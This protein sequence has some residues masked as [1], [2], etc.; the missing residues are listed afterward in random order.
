M[1][2][3]RLD[4]A[5]LTVDGSPLEASLYARLQRLCVRESVQL[6]DDVELRFDDPHF[7]LFDEGRFAIGTRLEVSMR[8]G[9]EPVLV[10]AAE[11]TALAVEPNTAGRHDLVVQGLDLTHR[12]ARGPRSRTFQDMNAADIAYR[13]AS[14]HGLQAKVEGA[15]DVLPYVVQAGETDY[16]LL[17][18]LAARGG[19]AV[20]V[21]EDTL[22][23]AP[24][25]SGDG[26]PPTL[27]WGQNLHRFT[28]R[29]ASVERTDE[30]QVHGWDPLTKR[31]VTGTAR[32][33]DLGSDAPA[34]QECSDQAR[35]AFG[36]V[37][38]HAHRIPVTDQRHAQAVATA[39]LQRAKGSEVTLRG[40]ASGAPD[41]GAGLEVDLAGVGQR[42]AGRY[43]VTAVEH[44][45]GAGQ[46]YVTRFVC[47]GAE[48]AELA[49]LLAGG[50]GQGASV[51]AAG[52]VKRTEGGLMVGVV[53]NND[54]REGL[55]RVKVRLSAISEEDESAWARVAVPGAGPGR[56]LQLLP[57]V[58][59]EVVVAFE[60]G[61]LSRPVVVGGLWNREDSP[62]LA[63]PVQRGQVTERGLTTR[64]GHRLSFR[65]EP[66]GPIDLALHED[67]C[68]LHLE[69]G[70]SRL[71]GARTL[72][73][74]AN[75]IEI[76]A[77]RSLSLSAPKVEIDADDSLTLRGKPIKLN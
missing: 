12:L 35:S 8:S 2:E 72:V 17:S 6:P 48:P 9:A 77:A 60:E 7:E 41:L 26:I 45:F 58:D 30:V 23:L 66:G 56:G 19:L 55:G 27:T 51:G 43:R 63:E 50:A 5:A 65:D 20:W 11:V 44:L 54:D 36:S 68:A 18:R 31:R 40:E 21:R 32:E 1:A 15:G 49:D 59:D 75:Q 62:P 4:S 64:E 22:H 70:E 14:E 16:A 24:R 52:G 38:R 69:R 47:G 57:E 29:F 53:T 61:E 42:L 28:A 25:V 3:R 37:V 46:P 34:A 73:V 33:A 67:V 10:T 39:L 13:I 74:S 76:K 71:A